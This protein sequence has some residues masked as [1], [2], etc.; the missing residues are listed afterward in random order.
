MAKFCQNCMKRTVLKTLSLLLALAMLLSACGGA[1]ETAANGGSQEISSPATSGGSVERALLSPENTGAIL[2]GVTVDV[3]DFVLDG[4]AELSVAKGQ[5]EDHSEDGYKLDVY[6]IKLGDLHELGDYITIRIPYDTSFWKNGQDGAKC[7]GAMYKNDATGAWENVL[8]EVDAAK[9]E[10]VI[11]TDHLSWYSV[12]YV[13]DEGRRNALVTDVKSSA[14]SMDR[15]TAINFA[16]RIAAND[17]SVK[18]DLITYGAELSNDFVDYAD[19]LD[20]AIN[21]ATL[22][23][24]PDWLDT[25]I[26]DTNQTLFSAIGYTATATN[27]M[28]IALKDSIGGGADKGA[29][30]SLIRDV[31][32]K[33]TTYWA[34]A[35]TTAG[36]GALSVGMAGV[37]IID[38]ML[39][40]FAEEAQST[41]MEDITFVYHHYNEGFSGPAWAHQL[42]TPKDWRAKVIEVLEKHPN[43]SEVAIAAL[44]AGFR[45]YASEFFDLSDD[46]MSEVASDVPNVT[47]KHIPNFTEAEKETLIEGY[48]AHLKDKTM[49]AVLKSVQNY[50]VNKA[51]EAELQA[52]NAVKD[53]YN[54]TITITIKEQIPEGGKSQYAG[55]QFRFAPLNDTAVKGNWSGKWPESGSAKDTST[56][57]GFMTAGYP[58]TVEF[59]KPGADMDTEKPEFTVPFVISIPEINIT[60]SGVP[61]FDEVVGVYEDGKVTI[62]DVFI[63]E[64]F[65]A[66]LASGETGEENELGCDLS[67]IIPSLEAQVG[68]SQEAP[69]TIKKTAENAG[70]LRMSEDAEDGEFTITYDP[71][72]GTIAAVY[73][74]DEVTLNGEFKAK[75]NGDKT[76]IEVSGDV[77]TDLGMGYDNLKLALRIDGTKPLA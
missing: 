50:M 30:L 23:D 7:V 10:V 49:P 65:R 15:A 31:G 4:E 38:K 33:V 66:A 34:D 25:S 22:G 59:F 63:S 29:V 72:S 45:K 2:N 57:I 73:E 70:V 26:P 64:S 35:F 11:Y 55:Y 18:K 75:Y 32:S 53:Y 42:M 77:L 14:L 37:L 60:I 56:L 61:T 5:S 1:K 9:Q 62:T 76:R 3:G 47:V 28:R 44:E 74:K 68:T 19:R 36:S 43:D 8:F 17:A 40:A 12:L 13:E 51:D 41:K 54:S 71:A 21:I 27:L 67:E 6:D 52:I 16:E 69:F 46:Q 58:H 39:T 48:I 24:I 20:N